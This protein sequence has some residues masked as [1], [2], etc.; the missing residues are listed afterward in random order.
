M[1]LELMCSAAV[2]SHTHTHTRPDHTFAR[3]MLLMSGAAAPLLPL[4]VASC[5]D[6][7]A[8][9]LHSLSPHGIPLPLSVVQRLSPRRD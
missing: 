5:H 9:P 8:F 6:C 3:R 7:R 2:D 4:D 1:A